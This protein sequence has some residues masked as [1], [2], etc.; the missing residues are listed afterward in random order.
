MLAYATVCPELVG[1]GHSVLTVAA[2]R[3]RA[4]ALLC[5]HTHVLELELRGG[6]QWWRLTDADAWGRRYLAGRTRPLTSSCLSRIELKL[7][8]V[9]R[10]G[11]G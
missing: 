8:L 5:C 3:A 2:D 9:S 10:V 11:M 7:D 6:Q 1:A 4:H